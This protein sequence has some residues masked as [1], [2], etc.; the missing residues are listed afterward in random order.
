M[1]DG[2]LLTVAYDGAAFAGW[3]RQPG[4][5]TVSDVVAQ[6]VETMVGGPVELRVA[7]RTDA[8]V[9]ALDQKVAFDAPRPLP[10]R[11]WEQGLGKLLPRDVSVRRAERCKEGYNPRFDA[12]SKLYEYLIVL[13]DTRDPLMH[14]RAWFIGPGRARPRRSEKRE[15]N[16]EAWL[17]VDDMHRAGEVFAGTHDFRAFRSAADP[18]LNTIRTLMRVTVLPFVRGRWDLIGIEVEGSAFLQHMVRIIV[19]T[20]LDVGRGRREAASVR[21]LLTP[22][23]ERPDAGETAPAHGLYLR[24]VRLGRTDPARSEG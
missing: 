2:T 6:S 8:G 20:L 22:N 23:A 1:A 12:S 7:S 5:R 19:G 24:Q 16:P 11:A 15:A 14:K 3:Q 18:R 21:D 17:A 13:G 10:P 9:H 4:Q